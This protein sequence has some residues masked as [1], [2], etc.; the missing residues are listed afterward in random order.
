MPWSVVELSWPATPASQR[1]EPAATS[2]SAVPVGT[3][4][5]FS[6]GAATAA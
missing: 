3:L 6:T 1:V 2:I 4:A 5:G